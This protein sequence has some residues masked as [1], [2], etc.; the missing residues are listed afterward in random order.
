MSNILLVLFAAI[1]FALSAVLGKKRL[2]QSS[3]FSI[4]FVVTLM[5]NILWPFAFLFSKTNTVNLEGIIFFAIAG[6]IGYG[7]TK[8]IYYKGMETVGVSV[9]SSIYAIFPIFSTILAVLLLNEVLSL[10]NWIGIICIFIGVFLIERGLGKTVNVK[11]RL[12]G[13]SKKDLVFPIIAAFTFALSL[14]IRKHGLNIYD[15]PLLSA[16]I[17]Y[18]TAFLFFVLIWFSSKSRLSLSIRKDFRLFWKAGIFGALGA[19]LISFALS[20]EQLSLVTPVSQTEPL[21]VIF[22]TYLYLKNTEQISY[23]LFISTILIVFGVILVSIG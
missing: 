10:W 19:G 8:L 9:N 6:I 13:I 17:G 12:Q 18:S 4:S 2:A 3:F 15:E 1:A 22:F 11:K 5:G 23:K 20:S 21:F 14:I 7:I 16:S